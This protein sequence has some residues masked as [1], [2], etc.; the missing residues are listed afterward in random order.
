MLNKAWYKSVMLIGALTWI[1]FVVGACDLPQDPDKYTLKDP[2]QLKA[3][4]IFGEEVVED[5][6]KVHIYRGIPYAAP[7]VGKL[8]WRPPQPVTPWKDVL[9]C[10]KYA[11]RAP[12]MELTEGEP[13]VGG[14]SEDCLHLNV[15]TAAKTTDR[16][17]VMVFF[18]G[19]G[20]SMHTANSPVYCN[21]ALPRKGVVVVTVNNRLGPLGYLAHPALSTESRKNISGNYG[22][23]DLI[24]A[25]TWVRNNI[26]AF[27]GDPKNVTIFGESGGGTKVLSVMSSPLAKGLF[28]KAIIESGSGSLSETA[29]MT[30]EEAEAAGE[31]LAA[32]LGVDGEKNVLKA[33]RSKSWEDIL[34]AAAAEDVGFRANLAI[35]GYVLPDSVYNIFHSGRQSDVPLIVG[36][37]E[38]E[39]R[40]LT[41]TVPELADSMKNVSSNAYVYV[42][43]HVPTGWRTQPCVAFHGLELPYVFG[44]IPDGIYANIVFFLAPGGGCSPDIDPGPDEMDHVVAENTMSLWSEFAATG[45]PSVKGLVVWPPYEAETDF[46][47]DI[48]Y[49]VEV[50]S[51]VKESAVTPP[52]LEQFEDPL[53]DLRP[54]DES[55]ETEETAA[56]NDVVEAEDVLLIDTEEANESDDAKK[57]DNAETSVAPEGEGVEEGEIENAPNVQPDDETDDTADTAENDDGEISVVPE[58][59]AEE[60]TN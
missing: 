41:G 27:G 23:L 10:T 11:D 28:H 20:L 34:E 4:K 45:D 21:T 31:R 2:I 36:A 1:I 7:P 59:S 46:Y 19:G 51:G 3:G 15:I 22:T 60:S 56:A 14:M 38:G 47:L 35:D 37:N 52:S 43:S 40:E 30:L 17:P 25:L 8:R 5:G 33:L 32:K 54:V 6:Q 58:D 13:G 12:Q 49:E 18:H 42:F 44:A 9:D 57:D 48:G 24:K 50:K 16:L 26:T 55:A 29:A 39:G 53:Q